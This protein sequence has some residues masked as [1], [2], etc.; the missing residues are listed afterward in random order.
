MASVRK[1]G[2]QQN[3]KTPE[4]PGKP[5]GSQREPEKTRKTGKPGAARI[6]P[7]ARGSQRGQSRF[8][9][10][11]ALSNDWFGKVLAT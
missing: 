11:L 8:R 9:L 2:D 10:C 5:G 1:G 6:N 4:N 7:R 3:Q